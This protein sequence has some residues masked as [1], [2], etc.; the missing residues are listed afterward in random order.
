MIGAFYQPEAVI[1]DTD[2]LSSL[3]HHERR[4]GFAEVIKH[5]SDPR[6]FFL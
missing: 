5:G 3:P 2:F 1:Y 6:S 4:S